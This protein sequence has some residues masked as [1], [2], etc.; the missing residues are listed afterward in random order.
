MV[1]K[2]SLQA[3]PRST[4]FQASASASASSSLSLFLSLLH[5]SHVHMAKVKLIMSICVFIL[6]LVLIYGGLMS[7]GRKLDIEKN[8]KCEMC[9]SIDEKISVLGNLHRSSKANARPH[10]PARQSPGADRLFTDDGVDVQSTTPGH[11]PGVGHSV[12]PASN[13]PNP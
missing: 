9:V 5:L 1:A 13:D 11:S 2:N 10:A 12:G 7:E 6:A 4:S 8:S 3:S